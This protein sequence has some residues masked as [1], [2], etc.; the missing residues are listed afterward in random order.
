[1]EKIKGFFAYP[2]K[3]KDIGECIERAVK[4]TNR[5]TA[6]LSYKTWEECDVNGKFIVQEIMSNIRYC[7]KSLKALLQ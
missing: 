2:S 7:W 3:L 4:N 6:Y 1:M 5:S